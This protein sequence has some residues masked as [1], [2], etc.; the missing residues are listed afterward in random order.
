MTQLMQNFCSIS[1]NP[2]TTGEYFYSKYFEYYG[3]SANYRA[4]GIQNL[5]SWIETTEWKEFHGISVSM[6]FK[7][8]VI[9][10]LDS[11]DSNVR[12]FESCNTVKVESNRW[13]GFNTDIHGIRA[14]CELIAATSSIQ[15]LGD[16]AMSR[17]FQLVLEE[18]GKTYEVFSRKA[19]NWATR[20][21]KFDCRINATSFGT[22]TLDSPLLDNFE[23]SLLI[24]LALPLGRLSAQCEKNNVRYVGG[25]FF[26]EQ[27]FSKQFE[28]YTGIQVDPNLFSYFLSIK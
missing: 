9:R 22:H 2:G 21:T 15:I 7:F 20:N 23:A 25:L 4:I 3:I 28:I 19:G 8:E 18:Q 17:G 16:G 24:D 6:P 11:M 10:H 1:L 14:V 5:E 12:F 13:E 26:Y 27:V